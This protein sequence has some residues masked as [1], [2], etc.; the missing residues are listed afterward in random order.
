MK[1]KKIIFTLAILTALISLNAKAEVYVSTNGKD[2]KEVMANSG[3]ETS[4]VI[5]IK[6]TDNVANGEKNIVIGHGA[7]TGDKN[8]TD[9]DYNKESSVVIGTDA[10]AQRGHS[11]VIGNGSSS[12]WKSGL[13]IGDEAKSL[14]I[15][16]IS[17]GKNSS[18]SNKN[19][20]AIG[21]DS[22]AKANNAIAIGNGTVN[23]G[24]NSIVLG[25]E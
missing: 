17:I 1:R 3:T 10:K 11:V 5:G 16:S 12:T 25:T 18:S 4:I 9:A 22:N 21:K 6:G 24:R 15:E 14:G 13:A 7:S 23:G 20:I 8:Y 2:K 19:S